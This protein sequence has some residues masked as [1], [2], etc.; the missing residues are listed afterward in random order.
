M[1]TAIFERLSP[2]VETPLLDPTTGWVSI[3]GPFIDNGKHASE[4]DKAV[5]PSHRSLR[6][7]FACDH[8]LMRCQRPLRSVPNS[9]T[10]TSAVAQPSSVC[11]TSHASSSPRPSVGASSSPSGSRCLRA[12]GRWSSDPVSGSEHEK[13]F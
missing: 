8:L 10:T 4:A 11:A 3:S 1:T 7:L 9:L 6:L 2:E 12:T 13:T 5:S